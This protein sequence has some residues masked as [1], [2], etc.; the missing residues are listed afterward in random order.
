[1]LDV[2]FFLMFS[3]CL[4]LIF[5]PFFFFFSCLRFVICGRMICLSLNRDRSHFVLI[6][7][8]EGCAVVVCEREW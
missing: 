3:K 4:M 2:F 5:F 7:L 1:M 8:D 6:V